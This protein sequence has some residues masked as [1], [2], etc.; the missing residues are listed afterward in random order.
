MRRIY[1][2]EVS[3]ASGVAQPGTGERTMKRSDELMLRRFSEAPKML[4]VDKQTGGGIPLRSAAL[5]FLSGLSLLLS[6]QVA[7]AERYE[8]TPQLDADVV[9]DFRYNLGIRTEHRD[10]AIANNPN[11]D[12]SDYRFN[13]GDVVTNRIDVTP[14]L[15]LTYNPDVS[16]V[17][18]V[19]GRISGT[20]FKDFAYSHDN[21]SCRPGTMPISGTSY[22]DPSVLSYSSGQYSNLTKD[23][24]FRDM[25]LLDAFAFGNFN[26]GDK[27]ASIK[28]GQYALFWGEAI[29][30]PVLG[31][32]YSQGPLDLNKAISI[33]GASVQD[34]FLPV[35]QV[36]GSVGVTPNLFV[37]FQYFLDWKP[38][39]VA[40]GGTYLN[41]L[42]ALY[43]GPDQFFLADTPFGPAVAPHIAP[44]EGDNHGKFGIQVK[45]T[46]DFMS[47]GALAAYYRRYDDIL[48]WLNAVFDPFNSPVPLDYRFAYA[49]NNEL[50]GVSASK[51]IFGISFGTDIVYSKNRA[52]NSELF[53]VDPTNA[54]DRARG[55]TLSGVVNAIYY[56]GDQS[57]GGLHLWDAAV[58]TTEVG[59]SYL[60]DVTKNEAQYKSTGSAACYADSQTLAG[61]GPANYIGTG[62][63]DGCSSRYS[64]GLSLAFSPTWY[65]VFEGVDLSGN[66]VFQDTLKNNSP[67]SGGGNEGSIG[68]SV[69]VSANIYNQY[70]VALAYNYYDSQLRTGTNYAGESV[71][72][73]FNG[74]GTVADR[75]WVS[76][77]LKYSF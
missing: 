28:V 8:I 69:G 43:Q 76:L 10:S 42:D 17:S 74:L 54:S 56:G 60:V 68:G 33:P 30:N 62:T 29:F 39:R 61:V 36:S 66:F 49:K 14:Q 53:Y 63:K 50:F 35:R 3:E 72:T 27:P 7:Q 6:M 9:V 48:P 15:T 46:P 55:N 52:L 57:L 23:R 25:E 34:I 70:T 45:W 59:W 41:S 32:S 58:L 40:E 4:R 11:F 37:G 26:I 38:A 31:V 18:K 1:H 65:Q 16:W 44:V 47:G 21:V 24:S 51:Q 77:T 71:V 5:F 2:Y 13:R 73:S 12:E 75:D 19:G 20:A 22:C 67:I 64:I